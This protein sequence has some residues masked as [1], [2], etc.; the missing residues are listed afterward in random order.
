MAIVDTLTVLFYF[1]FRRSTMRPSLGMCFNLKPSRFE[2]LVS[3]AYYLILN[4][5]GANMSESIVLT[6]EK[7]M[8]ELLKCEA[9][10]S[11]S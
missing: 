2:H 8:F 3:E 9:M 6:E 10:T 1:S 5:I 7:T 4:L 11:I